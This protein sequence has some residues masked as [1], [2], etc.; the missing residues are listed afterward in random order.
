MQIETHIE[1]KEMF[2][3]EPVDQAHF[4]EPIQLVHCFGTAIDRELNAS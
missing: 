4:Q 2:G 3:G 1:T